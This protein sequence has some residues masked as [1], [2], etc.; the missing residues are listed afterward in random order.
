MRLQTL[1]EKAKTSRTSRYLLNFALR[2]MIPF[3]GPHQFNIT[4]VKEQSLVITAPYI[5]KNKNHINGIHACALATLCEYVSGLSLAR[6][7]P[8]EQYRLILK[9]IHMEYHYQG[10]CA[11]SA[12][13]GI[14]PEETA[15]IKSRLEAEEAL[16]RQY[17]VAV[18]DAE[19][20]HICSGTIEWQIKPWTH[21]KVKV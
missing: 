1:L 15:I 3:N 20:K 4:H 13:F 16:L 14:S 19:N 12:E 17:S 6:A 8:P 9:S 11:V 10:K 2:R 5:R 7:L 21:V 18:Y